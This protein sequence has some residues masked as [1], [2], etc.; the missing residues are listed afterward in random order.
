VHQVAGEDKERDSHQGKDVHSGGHAL[1]HHNQ[2][3]IQQVERGKRRQAKRK[4]DRHP[5]A[6]QEQQR[7]H[8]Y[9]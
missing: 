9:G 1:E 5:Y 2:R 8:Q 7:A 3:N 6:E 4:C